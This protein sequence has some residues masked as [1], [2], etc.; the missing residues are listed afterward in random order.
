MV[1]LR[2]QGSEV[3]ERAPVESGDGEGVLEGDGEGSDHPS[4][5]RRHRLQEAQ[6]AGD[7][8]EEDARFPQG[9]GAQGRPHRMDYAR[10][11]RHRARVRFRRPGSDF[12]LFM[13][14]LS[15]RRYL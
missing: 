7:R 2:P 13:L 9:E 8:H 11:P 1:L 12:W 14:V 6:A 3:C 4:E 10:V 5:E 15:F